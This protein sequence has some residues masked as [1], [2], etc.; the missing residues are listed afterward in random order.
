MTDNAMRNRRVWLASLADSH[1]GVN[2]RAF[3]SKAKALAW[4]KECEAE[5]LEN[6][7]EEPV[8]DDDGLRGCGPYFNIEP[9]RIDSGD[10]IN[11]G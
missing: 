1:F 4:M 8:F 7:C 3:S 5:Y 6:G 9:V 2:T 11:E 10:F